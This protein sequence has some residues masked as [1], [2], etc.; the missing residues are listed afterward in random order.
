MAAPNLS[1][2]EQMILDQFVA[3][4]DWHGDMNQAVTLLRMCDWNV[5][6]R[7][8]KILLSRILG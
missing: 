2:E 4:S 6:V 1:Q 8:M 7:G 5:E 3:V